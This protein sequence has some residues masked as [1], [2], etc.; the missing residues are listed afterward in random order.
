MAQPVPEPMDT[1]VIA[2]VPLFG[3]SAVAVTR[4]GFFSHLKLCDIIKQV[5]VVDDS[6]VPN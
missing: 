4:T 2:S 5:V 6:K 1:S 3:R